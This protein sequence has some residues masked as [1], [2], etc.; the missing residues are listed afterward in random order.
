MKHALKILDMSLFDLCY[1][2]N[3]GPVISDDEEEAERAEIPVV[4]Y[5]NATD[6]EETDVLL[7][8][9]A[10]SENDLDDDEMNPTENDPELSLLRPE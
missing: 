2:S 5:D 3:F 1:N 9:V 6:D 4:E 8:F 7:N 10:Q